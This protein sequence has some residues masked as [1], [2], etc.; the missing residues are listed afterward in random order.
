MRGDSPEAPRAPTLRHVRSLLIALLAV[1]LAGCG[2][3]EAGQPRARSLRSPLAAAD[4][5]RLAI[6]EVL[7][8]YERAMRAG[9]G[10]TICARLLSRQPGGDCARDLIA[11]AIAGGGPRYR[12]IVTSIAVRGDRA[13]A[14]TRVTDRDGTQDRSQP[15]VRERGRWLL[16]TPRA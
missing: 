8:R 6:M 11:D 10:A 5:E 2:A 4:P 13:T 1:A 9:D 14:R 16:T 3:S 7:A 15:L 12:L